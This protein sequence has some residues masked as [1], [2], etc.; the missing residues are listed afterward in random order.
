MSFYIAEQV[1]WVVSQV[2]A[3]ELAA[4]KVGAWSSLPV[5]YILTEYGLPFIKRKLIQLQQYIQRR[6]RRLMRTRSSSRKSRPK[7]GGGSLPLK[8]RKVGYY[9]PP[10]AL[11]YLFEKKIEYQA[12][13]YAELQPSTPVTYQLGSTLGQGV[14][15][16]DRIGSE[17]CLI[18]YQVKMQ[19]NNIATIALDKYYLRCLVLQT[20][21][22]GQ[23]VTTNLFRAEADTNTPVDFDTSGDSLQII[24]PINRNIHRVLFDRKFEILPNTSNSLGKH[25]R[26][27][28]FYVDLKN[29]K[30]TFNTEGTAATRILPNITFMYFLEVE[31]NVGTVTGPPLV[32]DMRWLYFSG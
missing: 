32:S 26:L 16:G 25:H 7:H 15:R 31:D 17:I 12:R 2:T 9:P 11:S 28:E 30:C 29:Q 20:D 3:R 18:G 1:A 14:T 22:P 5:D 24:K 6:G 21:R 27:L 8:K 13:S 10:T 19:I 4:F 23:V